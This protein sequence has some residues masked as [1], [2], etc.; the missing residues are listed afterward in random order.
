MSPRRRNWV[1]IF[2]ALALLVLADRLIPRPEISQAYFDVTG[3]MVI[4]HQGGDGLRPSNTLLAF[5]HAAD[6]GVDVLEMDVHLTRDEALVLM[7]D[8][9]VDRTTDGS[10]A[11]AAMTLAEVKALDAAYHWPYEGPAPYRDRGVRVPTLAEVIERFPGLRYIVEMKPDTAAAGAALCAEL[12]RLGALHRTLVASFHK[13]AMEAFRRDC[14]T[15]PTSAHQGEVRR[16]YLL[17]RLGLSW[18]ARPQAAALQ[19]PMAADGR[20][21]TEPDFIA[22]VTGHMHLDYWT[23]NEAADMRLL[24]E[25]GAG[26]LITDRPDIALEVVAEAARR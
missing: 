24:I 15:V 16:F 6:L 11:L 26:G 5:Q 21:L 22:A 4:A 7:H 17:Y 25:R 8:A 19:I 23:V 10:G 2:L 20:D 12:T 13:S 3:P 1:L 18:L 9:T 14:P